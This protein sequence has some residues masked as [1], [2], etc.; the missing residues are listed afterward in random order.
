MS[1]ANGVNSELDASN[2]DVA[3]VFDNTTAYY[4][5]RGIDDPMSLTSK[6]RTLKNWWC[7][8][9]ARRA[10]PVSLNTSMKSHYHTVNRKRTEDVRSGVSNA[11]SSSDVALQVVAMKRAE[12]A[13]EV[14]AFEGMLTEDIQQKRDEYDRELLQ[15]QRILRTNIS[16][17]AFLRN[18]PFEL[19]DTSTARHSVGLMDV[20]CMYCHALRFSTELPSFCCE[21]GKIN[22]P[23]RLDPPPVLKSLMEDAGPRG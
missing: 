13:R 22:L 17:K 8:Q 16:T 14:E 19:F 18:G 21:N 7:N 6:A 1:L 12:F 20:E 5:R 15:A 9:V 10:H 23:L 2:G 3:K 4:G 11:R